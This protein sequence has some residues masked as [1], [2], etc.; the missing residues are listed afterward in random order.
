LQLWLLLLSS[1]RRSMRERHL[2]RRRAAPFVAAIVLVAGIGTG[3]AVA[4]SSGATERTCSHYTWPDYSAECLT[5]EDGSGAR[6]TVRRISPYNSSL[7]AEVTVVA[8]REPA[9]ERLTV[10]VDG[11]TVGVAAGPAAP[12][13]EQSLVGRNNDVSQ[14]PQDDPIQPALVLANDRVQVVIWR[15]GRPTAYVVR[16]VGGE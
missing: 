5:S 7:D 4:G 1:F 15:G 9:K 13:T 10:D 8:A 14:S 6:K 11:N 16:R 2:P 3:A 12:E